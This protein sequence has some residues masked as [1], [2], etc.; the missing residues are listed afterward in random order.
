MYRVLIFA[1]FLYDVVGI[2]KRHPQSF[3]EAR[4]RVVSAVGI[5]GGNF[6]VERM[7]PAVLFLKVKI[8]FSDMHMFLPGQP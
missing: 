3:E 1:C 8:H 2:R 6:Y 5:Q 4:L 7:L